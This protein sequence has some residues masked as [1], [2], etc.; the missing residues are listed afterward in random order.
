MFA[1][2]ARWFSI[3]AFLVIAASLAFQQWSTSKANGLVAEQGKHIDAA[4]ALI[5]QAAPKLD[6]L[7]SEATIAAFPGNRAQLEAN[8]RSTG[9]LYDKAAV[10]FRHASTKLDEASKVMTEAK[11]VEYFATMRDRWANKAKQM[12][13]LRD[14]VSALV[15]SKIENAESLRARHAEL[16][17]LAKSLDAAEKELKAKSDKIHAEY[18][19]LLK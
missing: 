14:Y 15:D 18:P 11:V 7:T 1:K 16:N 10:E 13:L 12:E 9:E 17:T 8:V 5:T 2:V 3:V 6:E 19:D 4:N